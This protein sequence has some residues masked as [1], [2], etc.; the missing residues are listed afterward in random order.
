MDDQ[1]TQG[2]G[3]NSDIMGRIEKVLAIEAKENESHWNTFL[4]RY[5]PPESPKKMISINDFGF[6]IKMQ[7][8][9]AICLFI[10]TATASFTVLYAIEE[11][12]L[13][14]EWGDE[15][16]KAS[17]LSNYTIIFLSGLAAFAAIGGLDGWMFNR[18]FGKGKKASEIMEELAEDRISKW[19]PWI[20]SSTMMLTAVSRAVMA[21]GGAVVGEDSVNTILLVIACMI[22]VA[23]VLVI[24]PIGK[25]IGFLYG[26]VEPENKRREAHN[27]AI[28][29]EYNRKRQEDW[30]EYAKD[31]VHSGD[32][33]MTMVKRDDRASSPRGQSLPAQQQGQATPRDTYMSEI[34]YQTISEMTGEIPGNAWVVDHQAIID[35]LAEKNMTINDAKLRSYTFRARVKWLKHAAAAYSVDPFSA[36]TPEEFC[37]QILAATGTKVDVNQKTFNEIR[38]SYG[39]KP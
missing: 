5:P 9:T 2:T 23:P 39:V 35:K 31:R 34:V 12:A 13:L 32:R 24:E 4:S 33:L 21:Y 22:G 36:S 15:S 28:L 11:R 8:I 37:K 7:T 27:N 20:I 29:A 25:D 1:N 19:S 30:E 16:G 10:L 14:S 38:D 26:F 18:G 3:N 17:G 6:Q